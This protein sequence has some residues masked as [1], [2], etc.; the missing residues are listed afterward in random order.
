[1]TVSLC[2]GAPSCARSTEPV[3]GR[4]FGIGGFMTDQSRASPRVLLVEDDALILLSLESILIDA[5]YAPTT[6]AT[7][8]HALASLDTNPFDAAILDVGL[9]DG[10]SFPLAE[11]LTQRR[12]PF[13]FCTGSNF[14]AM[15]SYEGILTIG[16][17]FTD[18]QV[19]D[20]VAQL[21]QPR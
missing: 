14:T 21:L 7:R 16:K 4:S 13:C 5:G 2:S 18:A 8:A 17:P 9:R 20:A 1:M 6:A 12:I 11:A 3:S 15:A 10:N 19:I